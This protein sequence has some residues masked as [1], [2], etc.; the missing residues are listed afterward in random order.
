MPP[1]LE[2]EHVSVAYGRLT[3]LDDVTVVIPD[4]NFVALLG[5]NGAGKSTFLKAVAGLVPLACG[6]LRLAGEPLEEPAHQRARRGVCLIPEG[7]GIFPALTV[8]ENLRVVVGE[9]LSLIHI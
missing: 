2:A 8:A 9:D 1:L 5:P 6:R 7:R 3:A 4:G